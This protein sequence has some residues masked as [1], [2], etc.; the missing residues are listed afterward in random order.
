MDEPPPRFQLRDKA[1]AETKGQ[2]DGVKLPL[3]RRGR[4]SCGGDGIILEGVLA[5][6]DGPLSGHK[7]PDQGGL[8]LLEVN[9]ASTRHPHKVWRQMGSKRAILERWGTWESSSGSWADEGQP[10]LNEKIVKKVLDRM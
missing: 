5:V 4:S 9:T 7:L 10:G 6:R 8:R 3:G 1:V 2:G